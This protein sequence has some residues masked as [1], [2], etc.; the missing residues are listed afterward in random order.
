MKSRILVRLILILM[1]ISVLS[2]AWEV[3]T[4][5]LIDRKASNLSTNLGEFLTNAQINAQN[6]FDDRYLYYTRD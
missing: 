5:R 6:G 4:H 3:N 1:T 2:H